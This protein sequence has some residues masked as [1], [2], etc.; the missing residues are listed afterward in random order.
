MGSS[1]ALLSSSARTYNRQTLT[2]SMCRKGAF[3]ANGLK[4]S[5]AELERIKLTA[6]NILLKPSELEP[7][8]VVLERTHHQQLSAHHDER[9]EVIQARMGSSIVCITGKNTDLNQNSNHTI[10]YDK[11]TSSSDLCNK[12]RWFRDFGCLLQERNAR[13]G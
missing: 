9:R 10:S 2:A 1:I 5:P 7:T 8:P 3:H 4:H 6:A 12:A 13:E 11:S